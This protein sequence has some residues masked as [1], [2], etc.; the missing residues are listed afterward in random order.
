MHAVTAGQGVPA[1][2]AEALAGYKSILANKQ[3]QRQAFPRSVGMIEY[4]DLVAG[5]RPQT[6]EEVWDPGKVGIAGEYAEES[7]KKV[8]PLLIPLPEEE[9]D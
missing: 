5:W 9:P 3:S 2:T 1:S 8:L 6:R 7:V 4:R